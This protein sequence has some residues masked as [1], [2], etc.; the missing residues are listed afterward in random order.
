MV[1]DLITFFFLL[2]WQNN[3]P[4]ADFWFSKRENLH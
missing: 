3:L 1:R 2:E 4:L